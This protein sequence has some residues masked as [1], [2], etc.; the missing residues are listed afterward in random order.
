VAA[1]AVILDYWYTHLQDTAAASDG[2]RDGTAQTPGTAPCLRMLDL[3]CGSGEA[4]QAIELW[5]EGHTNSRL[6]EELPPGMGKGTAAAGARPHDT[7]PQ[8]VIEAADPFTGA[9]YH[10]WT[11]REAHTWSFEDVAA[12]LLLDEGLRYHL[13]VSSYALHVM[14]PASGTLF[15][16][17]QQLALCCAYLLILSPHKLP[18][19]GG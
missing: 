15:A 1:T 2:S 16:C 7:R 4:S 18:K 13:V 14:D 6:P 10:Q 11:G 5:W 17:L 8:L 3:A 19:V 12:G 9:A